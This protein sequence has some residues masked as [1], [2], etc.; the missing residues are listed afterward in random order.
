MLRHREEV[1]KA[2]H[3]LQIEANE[4]EIRSRFG[5]KLAKIQVEV[6]VT[7]FDNIITGHCAEEL[8]AA[9][10]PEGVVSA[11]CDSYRELSDPSTVLEELTI[12]LGKGV[13]EEMGKEP[14]SGEES[15]Y[16]DEGDEDEDETTEFP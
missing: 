11:V 10:T 2:F 3:D 4:R 7:W 12:A 13:V 1:L 6:R 8:V 5:K 9:D 16:E 15:G 14:H